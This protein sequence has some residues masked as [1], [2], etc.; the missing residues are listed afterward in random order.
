[1][2]IS[3]GWLR[4]LVAIERE[5]PKRLAE[6]LTARGLTVDAVVEQ[7]GDTVLDLDV[8]ANRP[9]CLGH[10]GVAREIAAATGRPLLA[11]KPAPEGTGEPVERAVSVTV[12]AEDLCPRYTARVVRGVRI[13]PSPPEVVARL[14]AC[15][16]RSINS[17]VDVSNLVLLE[18]GQPVHTFDLDRIPSG[19]VRVRRARAD[20]RL[21]TLDGVERRLDSDM[22]VIAGGETA[23]AM[24]G[25]IGGAATEIGPATRNV[26]VEAASFLPRSVRRTAKR[27]GLVTDASQRFERGVDPEAVLPAQDL[28]ASLLA[29]LAGGAPAPGVL[30]VRVK[31][32][33]PRTLVVRRSRVR[34][35]LGFDP[36]LDAMRDALAALGLAPVEQ[37]EDA[38]RV[39]VPSFRVDLEREA[40]LVEEIG[41][42][43][44]Y[45][46]IPSRRPDAAAAGAV[47]PVRAAE[48][49]A[50]DLLS[51]LGFH[52]ATSYAMVP[53]GDDA[54]F[55]APGAPEA[56]AI[57]NPIAEGFACLRRS[58]LP[59]LLRAV[60]LNL[61][62]GSAD[63]RLF[64]VG[65]VFARKEPGA[66][67]D[68]PRHVALAWSGAASPRWHGDEPREASLADVAGVAETLLRALRPSLA[69]DPLPAS[70][71]GL[72]PG[73]SVGWSAAGRLV[74]IAGEA[75][76][77]LRA[78]LDLR[79]RVLLAEL[80][81]EAL[82]SIPE[83]PR[84]YRPIPRVPA[85][86][87]DLSL[88]L[89]EGVAYRDV[90]AALAAEPAPAPATFELVD[91][92][93]GPPLLPGQVSMT[94]RVILQPAE[95]TLQDAE[96]EEYR[97]RLVAALDRALSVKL[98][99]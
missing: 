58:L 34:L 64:E 6:I 19:K 68:E 88:V 17:V 84:A 50:R 22:L 52:E 28:A 66:F 56:L 25:V 37:P 32:A 49:R 89:P 85:V 20:E 99:A 75:H 55:V 39:T 79:A 12:E 33:S 60:D 11:R 53:A 41:R 80:D 61:R 69:L 59:G 44:G 94:V 86:T 35:L 31:A 4:E 76:P 15:G 14:E 83:P 77:D 46:R 5:D 71:P 95:R 54:P 10:L 21:T 42:H 30:D 62:R 82:A 24:G 70:R 43:L 13:A 8:P 29:S 67:P 73:R 97:T 40:D 98:R 9:D 90:V 2:R 57:V 74:G 91:R 26:L 92:Y 96:T 65:R 27:L 3:L 78:S 38:L 36:G 18:T 45:D 48:E 51:D 47:S 93:E 81:L 16:L 1:M 63:V 87:R 23:I 72:H 7:G